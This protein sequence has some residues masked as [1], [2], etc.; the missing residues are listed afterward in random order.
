V[1]IESARPSVVHLV[2]KKVK[3][4]GDNRDIALN[5]TP[6]QSYGTPLAMWDQTVLPIPEGW[7]AELT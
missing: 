4:K 7:K 2:K 6:S 5:D 1:N 3:V